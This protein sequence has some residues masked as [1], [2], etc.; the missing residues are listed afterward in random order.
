MN[1]TINCSILTPEG[2]IYQ[3]DVDLAVVQGYDGELGFLFNHT[4]LISE[5]G[6]GEVRLATKSSAESLVVEGGVVE[7]SNNKMIILA[8]NA[9]KK[10]DLNS[11]ELIAKLK[12]L[13]AKESEPFSEERIYL[14]D[15]EKR[16][17][18]R[19]QVA[20]KK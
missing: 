8:E 12:E 16:I 9:Y 17:K 15:Q 3:G 19:L 14:K 20:S 5:L 10:E 6:I 4:P 18:V 11:E 2:S 13:E 1:R 7:I